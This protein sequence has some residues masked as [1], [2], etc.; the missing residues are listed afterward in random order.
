MRIFIFIF[1]LLS[2]SLALSATCSSSDTYK[3]VYSPYSIQ[4]AI[5]AQPAGIDRSRFYTVEQNPGDTEVWNYLCLRDQPINCQVNQTTIIGKFGV[6]Y[7][8]QNKCP[9]SHPTFSANQC[10]DSNNCNQDQSFVAG[11]CINK[12]IEQITQR[13]IAAGAGG[14]VT[15]TV[16][17]SGGPVCTIGLVGNTNSSATAAICQT[18]PGGTA[19][20]TPANGLQ[21]AGS[22]CGT[23][24]GSPI[25]VSSSETNAIGTS[26]ASLGTSTQNGTPRTLEEEFS[27]NGQTTKIVKEITPQTTTTTTVND[28]SPVQEGQTVNSG[29]GSSPVP[30]VTCSNGKPAAN[31]QSCDSNVICPDDSYIA[32][33]SCIKMP[34]RTTVTAKDVTVTTTTVK[35]DLDNTVVSQRHP[36]LQLTRLLKV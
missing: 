23:F 10:F 28:S 6:N 13:C 5:N 8:C 12:K 32:Y 33:G 19:C 36:L 9:E 16:P 18:A 2:S 22:Q 14:P 25:C 24:N 26:S 1:S 20:F 35:N 29:A 27:A 4:S 3:G 31:I 34:T 11:A 21:S 30:P 15:V 7:S 17:S